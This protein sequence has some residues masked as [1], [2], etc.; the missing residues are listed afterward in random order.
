MAPSDLP[1]RWFHEG[2]PETVCDVVTQLST[3]P[4]RAWAL[5]A[6]SPL[7]LTGNHTAQ[8]PS[9]CWGPDPG[10][11]GLPHSLRWPSQTGRTEGTCGAVGASG[12]DL[13]YSSHVAGGEAVT[14]CIVTGE[15][16]ILFLKCCYYT[17]GEPTKAPWQDRLK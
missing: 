1:L 2:F 13:K 8:S 7:Q 16:S 12:W 11:R 4:P 5:S 9:R 3:P 15:N 14:R 10:A 17:L 6:S